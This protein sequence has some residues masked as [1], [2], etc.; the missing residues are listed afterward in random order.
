MKRYNVAVLGATG[1]VGREMIRQLEERRF[2]VNTLLPLASARSAGMTLSFRGERVNVR[3]AA[4]GAFEGMD[5][6]LGAAPNALAKEMAPHIKAV[7]AVFIDNSSAFRDG[8]G[9]AACGAGDQ[10]GGRPLPITG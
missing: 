10:S 8:S 6:V 7:G 5:I 1:A 2:P 4:P 9:G 3:E